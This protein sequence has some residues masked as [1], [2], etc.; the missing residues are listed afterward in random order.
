MLCLPRPLGLLLEP[1]SS[2]PVIPAHLGQKK[3]RKKVGRE[4]VAWAVAWAVASPP[5]I[6]VKPRFDLLR[7]ILSHLRS[8]D[9][10]P[11]YQYQYHSQRVKEQ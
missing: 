5:C 11:A 8:R 9:V 3:K 4:E 2:P 7:V 1:A 10:C 6:S